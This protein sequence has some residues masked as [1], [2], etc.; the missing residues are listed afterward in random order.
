MKKR[1]AVTS[2]LVVL[3]GM[4]ALI[5]S[6]CAG[7][8]NQGPVAIVDC[9]PVVVHAG[10]WVDFNGTSSYDPDGQIVEYSWDFGR[11]GTTDDSG[12]VSAFYPE[13][14]IFDV[15][16]TVIDDKGATN[17]QEVVLEVLPREEANPSFYDPEAGVYLWAEDMETGEK[18]TGTTPIFPGVNKHVAVSLSFA[19]GTSCDIYVVAHDPDSATAQVL[20][21]FPKGVIDWPNNCYARTQ[22]I[23]RVRASVQYPGG[24]EIIRDTNNLNFDLASRSS[25]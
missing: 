8:F 23:S 9:E 4:L 2:T 14:G 25:R 13:A 3:V 16:L 20:E 5:L 19:Q 18:I 6:G 1:K 22:G 15:S 24:K 11:G 7:L 21:L 10:N 17:T 12:T